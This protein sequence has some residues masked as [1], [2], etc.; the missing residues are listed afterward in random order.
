[1]ANVFLKEAN[2]DGGTVFTA[3]NMNKYLLLGDRAATFKRMKPCED[4]QASVCNGAVRLPQ[5]S[6][7]LAE[8]L[9]MFHASHIQFQ[10]GF[11]RF[12]R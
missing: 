12:H 3:L 10:K 1:M 2:T 5:A 9:Q 4:Q 8:H 7:N 6:R 11:K